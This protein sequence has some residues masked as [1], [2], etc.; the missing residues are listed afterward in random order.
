MSEQITLEQ[1]NA[2]IKEI[3][4]AALK[5]QDVPTWYKLKL[6]KERRVEE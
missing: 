5:D 1:F 6:L 4:D 3:N 2:R